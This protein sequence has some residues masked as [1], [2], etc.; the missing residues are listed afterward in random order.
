MKTKFSIAAVAAF[1]LS[2]AACGSNDD[3]IEDDTV[4]AEYDAEAPSLEDVAAESEMAALE[5]QEVALEEEA[6][7][8]N[9]VDATEITADNAETEDVVGM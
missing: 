1:G 5:E 3:V 9:A 7:D 6:T 4:G 2:L 8:P